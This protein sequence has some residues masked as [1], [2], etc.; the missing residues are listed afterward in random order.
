MKKKA[1]ELRELT[2]AEL[3][4]M[5]RE[6]SESLMNDR[7]KLRLRQLDNALSVR[8]ARRELAVLKTVIA[9]KRSGR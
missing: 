1:A 6:K 4:S 9:E 2:L 3:E 7:M 8:N 5:V